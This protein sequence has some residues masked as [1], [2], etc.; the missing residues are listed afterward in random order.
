V[1]RQDLPIDDV[2]AL[3]ARLDA[4]RRDPDPRA[5]I[6]LS[7]AELAFLIGAELDGAMQVEVVGEAL[8]VDAAVPRPEGGCWN[9]VYRGTLVIDGG[10]VDMKPSR[11]VV[12]EL[13]LGWR[14][15]I[16]PSETVPDPRLRKILG[17][18]EH[19]EIFGGKLRFS[20]RDRAL[21]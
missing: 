5:V 21:P 14:R 18:V 6:E 16:V 7:G 3:V 19:L 2:V 9:V 17:N 10:V 20:L 1:P 15:W 4:Y 11:L 12:G 13:D 8:S